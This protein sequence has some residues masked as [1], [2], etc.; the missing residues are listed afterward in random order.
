M[1]QTSTQG[2]LESLQTVHTPLV[3][4]VREDNTGLLGKLDAEEVLCG[5]GEQ[6]G[7]GVVAALQLLGGQVRLPRNP[8]SAASQCTVV[9]AWLG[10]SADGDG[11]AVATTKG[12]KV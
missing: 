1:R 9:A 12:R 4:G 3:E 6:D 7:G 8:R 11:G 10:W 2:E 5:G